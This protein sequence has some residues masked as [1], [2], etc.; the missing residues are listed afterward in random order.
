MLA[1]GLVAVAYGQSRPVS[2]KGI[3]GGGGIGKESR[4][5]GTARLS[6]RHFPAQESAQDLLVSQADVVTTGTV[7]WLGRPDFFPV[8]GFIPDGQTILFARGRLLRGHCPRMLP[9]RFWLPDSDLAEGGVLSPRE[10]YPGSG[11]VFLLFLREERVPATPI[12]SEP[13]TQ[14]E[15]GAC[16]CILFSGWLQTS[17]SS[18]VRYKPISHSDGVYLATKQVLE[19]AQRAVKR[20]R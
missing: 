5:E 6:G 20:A 8:S 2:H 14:T 3:A 13:E 15:C 19:I 16:Q 1:F 7:E 12:D 11:A 4:A 9:V 10:F 17:P 18:R